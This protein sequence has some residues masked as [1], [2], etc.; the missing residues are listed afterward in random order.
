M[1][2]DFINQS[3]FQ[4]VTLTLDNEGLASR[5][6][7]ITS[8]NISIINAPKD[9]DCQIITRS[10]PINIIGEEEE[11]ENLSTQ[12]IIV[13]VDLM[14]Y[15]VQQSMTGSPDATVS[16]SPKTDD[17]SGDDLV[18]MW[19]VGNYRVAVYF[20]EQVQETFPETSSSIIEAE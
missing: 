10:M 4:Q 6:V 2:E 1:K 19:A 17:A 12:D 20:T 3:G 7:W 8:D 9:Y 15:N 18:R 14:N 13:T 5:E 16:I 11:L